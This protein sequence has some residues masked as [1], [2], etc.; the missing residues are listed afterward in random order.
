M[1]SDYLQQLNGPQRAAVEY[2]DGPELVIAGAGSGKTRVLTYKIMH[3]LNRGIAPGRIL[4]LTF[5]NK[6]AREMRERIRRIAGEEMSSRLWMGTFHS[7]FSRMLRRHADLLGFPSNFTIYDTSDTKSLIKSIIKELH[8][9]DNYRPGTIL[10]DISNAKNNLYSPEDY[11]ADKD[12]ARSDADARRPRTAE[13]YR[14]YRNRCRISGAMD[15]DDLLFYTNVL[16]RDHPEVLDYYR[17]YFEYVLVDEYQ[18]TNFAQHLIVRQ[19]CS[20]HGHLCVVGDDAQSIYSFRGANIRNILDL[21]KSFPSLEIFKLEQNYRSTSN[22][23]DAANS[24]IA[25]NVEQ[26]PKEVFSRNGRGERIE[27]VQCYNDYEEGY[28][29]A[30]RISQVRMRNGDN[31]SDMAILYRTNA[32]SRVLEEALRNRNIPYRIYGGLAFY[33]RKEIKDAV[34]YFRLAVN[35]ND[36]EALRRVINTPRRGIGDT[37]VGKLLEG[38]I[39]TGRSIFEVILDPDAAFVT[40]SKSTRAKLDAFA[41]MISE[42]VRDN[43]AGMPAPEL[44]R[45]I[46]SKT[47]LLA[48]YVNAGNSPENISKRDNLLELINAIDTSAESHRE[49]TEGDAVFP[50]GEFLAEIALLTDADT[51]NAGD[52]CVTLMTIHSAK[53]L[54]YNSVF[55]VGV[56]EDLLPSAMSTHSSNAAREVE[57]ERRLMYVALTRAKRFCMITYAKKRT[58]NGKTNMTRPS[59]FLS[60]I[61][62]NYLR[63]MTG[64]TLESAPA[65][66]RTVL[67][68]S[69]ARESTVSPVRPSA[70]SAPAPRKVTTSTAQGADDCVLHSASELQAGQRIMHPRFGTGLLENIDTAGTDPRIAVLFDDGSRRTLLLK[71]AKFK[72]L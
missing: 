3:L 56:E 21:R 19:L 1:E 66:R 29:V 67:D 10:S 26:I 8:L 20:S 25:R 11:A 38:A 39:S 17:E 59:R 15:F 49:T 63:L 58:I 34:C 48:E 65:P 14:I 61:D 13:I 68:I 6:A 5:T 31:Y 45:S 72:L 35:P 33:Q 37:T 36:D 30:N 22:I 69:P 42:F 7:I 23:V 70:I 53:G 55:I 64:S 4:A 2:L 71:F 51:Q 62:R 52:D 43:A 60:E 40:L 47:G 41:G 28:I 18:D 24:L 57:E 44:A 9:D 16:L 46:F 12:I 50:M 27:V 32:Q 54:E